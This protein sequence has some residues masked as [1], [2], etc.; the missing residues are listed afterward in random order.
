M[1]A[2]SYL[3]FLVG[4]L[5][6]SAGCGRT[7]PVG[8]DPT[9]GQGDLDPFSDT[10]PT[11]EA[12]DIA[13]VPLGSPLDP[14]WVSL[15]PLDGPARIAKLAISDV[16]ET[17]VLV[18]QMYPPMGGLGEHSRTTVHG[19]ASDG[20]LLWT[21]GATGVA[22][23]ADDL[24]GYTLIGTDWGFVLARR[25]ERFSKLRLE[26]TC[27]RSASAVGATLYLIEDGECTQSLV[28]GTESI[29]AAGEGV[30]FT[31]SIAPGPGW[32]FTRYQRYKDVLTKTD[33]HIFYGN[34]ESRP[35]GTSLL[36]ADL[37]R[38]LVWYPNSLDQRGPYGEMSSLFELGWKANSPVAIDRMA[39]TS[40]GRLLGIGQCAGA[41][42]QTRC[43]YEVDQAG[44][45][46]T[47]AR[48]DDFAGAGWF[49]YGAGVIVESQGEGGGVVQVRF[50]PLHG[51]EGG[52]V[53]LRGDELG[54]KTWTTWHEEHG[55]R[56]ALVAR[57]TIEIN[58]RPFEVG[59]TARLVVIGLHP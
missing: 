24:P 54:T 57:G 10:D 50:V 2:S 33:Y 4:M 40:T 23:G 58:G 7:A 52:Y 13:P 27:S 35:A 8:S 20:E 38:L 45:H 21:V 48:I 15:L 16:G 14:A 34:Q 9:S 47:L 29:V 49:L 5:L 6:L 55:A 18:N 11:S 31:A 41:G 32:S 53:T 42:A 26:F 59:P 25:A 43:I 30:L 3:V 28:G 17:G 1:H 51:A 44:T 19:V 56:L 12:E 22:S 46:T 39:A 37:S 36:W